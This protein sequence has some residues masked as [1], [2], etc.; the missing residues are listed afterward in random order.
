[1]IK[2]YK[3]LI[4][5]FVEKNKNALS[6][7]SNEFNRYFYLAGSI[8]GHMCGKTIHNSNLTM[9]FSTHYEHGTDHAYGFDVNDGFNSHFRVEYNFN[10]D[11]NV[12]IRELVLDLNYFYCYYR[13]VL[14]HF[15]NLDILL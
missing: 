2:V 9:Q 4:K 6:Q 8:T 1:M 12:S 3:L 7:Y 13:H 5:E 14:K 10:N 15:T 11:K